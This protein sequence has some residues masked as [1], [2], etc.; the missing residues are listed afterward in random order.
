MNTKI[1]QF[2]TAKHNLDHKVDLIQKQQKQCLDYVTELTKEQIRE[3]LKAGNYFFVEKDGKILVSGYRLP[4]IDTANEDEQIYRL[5]GLSILDFKDSSIENRK[6]MLYLFEKIRKYFEE[7][8]LQLIMKTDNPTLA[9]I[10]RSIGAEELSYND[11]L[12][13]YP[14]FLKAYIDK[15]KKSEEYY[16]T[17]NF[18]IRGKK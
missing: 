13:K 11:C 3:L 17:Q 9:R 16:Q 1:E 15:S 2:S 8:N 12:I 18:Y 10:L 4:L 7:K 6:N 14:K 5:G